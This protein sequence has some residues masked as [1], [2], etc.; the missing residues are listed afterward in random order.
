MAHID[1]DTWVL[2]ADSE[3]ALFLKN[4][5]DAENP[6]L[7]VISKEE[8]DNPSNFAQS[9]NRPGRMPD[10][11]HSQR[12]ALD[13]TDWHELAKDRFASHLAELLYEKAHRGDYDKIVLCLPPQVIGR[14]RDELHKEV[15]QKVVGE[16]TKLLTKHP[17]AEIEKILKDELEGT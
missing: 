3:K 10:A 2:V 1:T 6:H 12:S 8:Q 9:A 7:V 11:G 17:I 15:E 5:A 13:D 14:V 16:V 4:V